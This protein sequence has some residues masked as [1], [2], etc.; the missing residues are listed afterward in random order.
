MRRV[1]SERRRSMRLAGV[2]TFSWC[3]QHNAVWSFLFIW[4]KIQFCTH[5]KKQKWTTK[6]WISISPPTLSHTFH[7]I[8]ETAILRFFLLL[9]KLFEF[10]LSQKRKQSST[11]RYGYFLPSLKWLRHHYWRWSS[12]LMVLDLEFGFF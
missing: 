11:I 6:L 5:N 3:A 2:L 10:N 12:I 9:L 8:F 1:G 4:L 7:H